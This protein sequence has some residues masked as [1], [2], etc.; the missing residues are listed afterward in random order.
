M[1]N[2]NRLALPYLAAAQ[3]QKHVTHNEALQILDALVQ[4]SVLARDVDAPPG[5]PA[6]GARY[7]VGSAPSGAFAGQAGRLAAFDD[8]AW[9]FLEPKAGW[10]VHVATSNSVIVHD[11]SAWRDIAAFVR[12]LGD[13]AALGVGTGAD[14][15]N[16]FSAKL[17]DALFAARSSAEGGTGDLRLKLNK[18]ASGGVVS[19]LF[20]S[21]WS[22]RA[23]TGLSGDDR[24]RIKVSADGSAWRDSLVADP[25]TG[26]V[27]FPSG[28]GD[29]GGGGLSELRNLV[30]NG[31]FSIAQRGAGPFVLGTTAAY[32]FD[33][34]LTQ[35]G[36]GATGQLARTAF[37]PGQTAGPTGRF[38]ATFS[39]T[40]TTPASLPELQTRME[41][42]NRLA[43]RPITISFWY[44]TASPNVRFELAQ[45]FGAAGSA[46][47]TGIS[48][49]SLAASAGWTFR[50]QV[51]TLPAT[52]GKTVGA[53]SFT[54]LRF[55]V[56][57]S[58]AAAFDV[59]DV[60]V[61]E[62]ILA[63]PFARRWPA[64]DML[65]ASRLFRRTATARNT[66][67][68]AFEMRATPVVSGT[69]PFN[70]SAEL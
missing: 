39:L 57:G 33:G 16:P 19:Q 51:L 7:L 68:L 21:G 46:A 62:G 37:D 49:S 22:G 8:G 58:S 30:L 40:A 50:K 5:P 4:L 24:F 27:S 44:R 9:R 23:E 65:L 54:S 45:Q 47:V 41:D 2:S 1:S 14:A 66:A 28:V 67:D 20:Q 26:A 18:E 55:I 12:S 29:M 53:G 6:E 70:Y 25:S 63:T 11:G 36:V 59:A 43:A 32:G 10:L 52:A 61:E 34:W 31:D 42:V 64:I 60:Q 13:L 48:Q 17:N 15:G 69:G 38:Y 3:S 35:T 56:T